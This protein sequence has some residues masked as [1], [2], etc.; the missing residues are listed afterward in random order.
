VFTKAHICYKG[1]NKQRCS[2]EVVHNKNWFYNLIPDQKL[3]FAFNK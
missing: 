3:S 1:N 2:G